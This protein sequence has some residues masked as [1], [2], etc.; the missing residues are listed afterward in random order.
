MKGE[1]NAVVDAIIEGRGSPGP[2]G[3]G[4]DNCIWNCVGQESHAT[5]SEL[6][7]SSRMGKCGSSV[8]EN[9]RKILQEYWAISLSTVIFVPESARRISIMQ[10]S[11]SPSRR[12][13][14]GSMRSIGMFSIILCLIKLR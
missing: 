5:L 4:A 2:R 7:I 1:R 3:S 6:R 11:V 10:K 9:P 8:K 14:R 12:L 13:L